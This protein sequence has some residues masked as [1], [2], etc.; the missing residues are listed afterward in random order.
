MMRSTCL[1]VAAH[2][3]PDGVLGLRAELVRNGFGSAVQATTLISAAV[4]GT[5]PEH[6]D[7][8]KG[9]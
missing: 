2:P 9:I 4:A 3:T 5:C 6:L 1:L 7:A 8:L